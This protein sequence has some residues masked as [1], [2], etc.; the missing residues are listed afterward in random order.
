MK[1]F[2]YAYDPREWSAIV[3]DYTQ[4]DKLRSEWTPTEADAQG[5]L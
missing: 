5:Q 4:P 3:N 2:L 1:I